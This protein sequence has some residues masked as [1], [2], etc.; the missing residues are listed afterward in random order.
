MN[1]TFKIPA[2]PV[3]A[4]IRRDWPRAEFGIDPIQGAV[5]EALGMR[6]ASAFQ[7]IYAPDGITVLGEEALLRASLRRKPL[8]PPSAFAA[9]RASD[10]LVAFDR[11][12]RTLHLINFAAYAR[13]QRS[14]FLN[15]HPELLPAVDAHGVYFE[16]ILD[17]QGFRPHD[18]VLELLESDAVAADPQALQRAVGNF[19]ARGYRIALDDFGHAH[20]NFDR[21]WAVAPDY[22]KLD[23]QLLKLASSDATARRGYKQLATLLRDTGALVLAKGVETPAQRELALEAGVDGL[24]GYL[25]GEPGYRV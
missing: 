3:P 19:R 17:S 4:E 15:V 23:R 7:P 12:C 18:V 11:L 21:L 22:V 8:A 16:R 5:T 13:P 6:L 9:A 10:L 25:L 24:Q 2:Y 1:D 14:L 20:A